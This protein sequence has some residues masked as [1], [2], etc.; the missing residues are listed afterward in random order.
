MSDPMTT[1]TTP[2]PPPP[3][4]TNPP[5]TIPP[6]DNPPPRSTSPLLWILLVVA[7]L[8]LAWYLFAG[9]DAPETLPDTTAT[10]P[11]ADIGADETPATAPGPGPDAPVAEPAPVA[12]PADRAATPIA[13]LQP[14]YPREAFQA[15]EEG[16]VLLRAQVDSSGMTTDVDV[17]DSS[18]S[19]DLDRAATEAVREWR[20][21]PAL[22]DGQ[23][24]ASTV[25]VPV[26][27]DLDDE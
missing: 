13:R 2:P 25:E 12:V 21:E 10:T 22:E 7:L 4:P 1:R 11:A 18:H 20:F 5:G 27:F 3:P 24:V 23:A 26:T 9:R 8:A 19:R 17:I 6:D 16:M 14:E 15:R